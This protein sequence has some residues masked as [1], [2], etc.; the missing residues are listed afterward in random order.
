[1]NFIRPISTVRTVSFF[2]FIL[3][4]YYDFIIGDKM[5]INYLGIWEINNFSDEM[6]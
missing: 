1:M 2:L 5:V 3:E 4:F 6:K